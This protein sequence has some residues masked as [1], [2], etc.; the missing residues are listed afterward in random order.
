MQNT[1][2]NNFTSYA[3]GFQA[4]PRLGLERIT[5]LMQLLGNPQEKLRCIHVAGTNGKGST[6][7]FLESM[8]LAA[9]YKVGKYISPNLV[10]VNERIT[11]CREEISD[12]DLDALLANIEAIIP[13]AEK[14]LSD[15]ISQFEIWTAAMFCYFAEKNPDYVVLE[16]GLGGEF[17]ATNVISRN[18]M[19]VLTQIDIDH[20]EYLGDT[21]EKIAT[22]KSKIIK[23]DCE[24]G[25]TVVAKQ[26][27]GA[28]PVIQREAD[29]CGTRLIVPE[30]AVSEGTEEIYEIISYGGMKHLR[31][32]LG[33]LYQIE[34]ACTAI[35]CA[36]ALGLSEDAIRQGLLEAKNPARFEMIDTN[37][38]VIY[39]G[40]HNP[41]GVRSLKASLDRYYPER[42]R[43]VVFAC[44]ADKDFMPSLELLND[45][46]SRFVFT[47]VQNNPRAMGAEALRNAAAE[48]GIVGEWAPT[49]KEAITL[50]KEKGNLVITC[51]SL[52]LYADLF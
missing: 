39:D 40:G 42:E 25:V 50:A 43:T 34:N 20:V 38:N 16:T 23:K 35:E 1:K 3:N 10:R 27:N 46:H 21:I 32:G 9:G 31:L 5:Y 29:A 44:M 6:C 36:R 4:V 12:K 49:L 15:K 51:G 2:T 28:I 47:T 13:E 19:S 26:E 7:A 45:G 22:T 30:D 18:V 37:P 33:G 48:K 52:Y 14:A 8:L 11:Y 24:S 17:D 41:N